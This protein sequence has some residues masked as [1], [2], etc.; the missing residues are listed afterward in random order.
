MFNVDLHLH[1]VASTHAYSTVHDYLAA[2]VRKGI[3]LIAITDHGPEMVDAP[4]AFHFNNM[5]ILPRVVEG[6][7][8]LRGIEANIKANGETDCSDKM[9]SALDLIIAGFHKQVFTPADVVTNTKA[10][11]AVIASGKVHIISH[12]G[13]PEYP[14]DIPAVVAAAR[15]YDVALEVNNASFLHSRRGSEGNCRRIVA[16]VRDEGGLLSLGTDS[17]SAFALGDFSACQPLLVESGFPEERI[18][19]GSPQRVLAFLER[20]GG[21]PIAELNMLFAKDR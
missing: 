8:L 10:M 21:E 20:R 14:I 4:H 16:A 6:V 3:R 18:L 7:G 9:R 19:N 13:N 17:H 12:P 1:T 2:A 15:E 5:R 11:I